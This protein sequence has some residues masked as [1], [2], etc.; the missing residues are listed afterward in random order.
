M[1]TRKFITRTENQLKYDKSMT[2]KI[3]ESKCL[4]ITL[5]IIDLLLYVYSR[6]NNPWMYVCKT[7]ILLIKSVLRLSVHHT[8]K[9]WIPLNQ[10]FSTL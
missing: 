3:H 8:C 2:K 5:K 6:F 9:R 7:Y 10:K 1:D 4:W